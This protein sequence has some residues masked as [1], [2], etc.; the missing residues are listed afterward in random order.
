ML[1]TSTGAGP[2]LRRTVAGVSVALGLLLTAACSDDGGTPQ[3]N[4]QNTQPAQQSQPSQP[5]GAPTDAPTTQT[6]PSQSPSAGPTDDQSQPASPAPDGGELGAP[7]A[8]RTSG[9]ESGNMKFELFQPKR[10]NGAVYLTVRLTA[11]G[12]RARVWYALSDSNR[13]AGDAENHAPDGFQLIDGKNKKIYLVAHDGA[14]HCFCAPRDLGADMREPGVPVLVSATF[15]APPE[16][17]KTVDIQVPTFGM[18][19]DVPLG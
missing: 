18:F 2:R 4:S 11:V 1:K 6:S 3:G 7:V 17:V 16:D 13:E 8:T 5:G 9:V 10:R 19:V 12:K 15:A 14:G